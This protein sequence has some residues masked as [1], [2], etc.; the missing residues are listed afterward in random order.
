MGVLQEAQGCVTSCCAT[1]T[2]SVLG[3]QRPGLPP[4]CQPTHNLSKFSVKGLFPG[5]INWV[6]ARKG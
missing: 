3:S 4:N 2:V 6:L 1:P 5:T